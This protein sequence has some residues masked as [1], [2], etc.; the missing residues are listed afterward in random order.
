MARPTV[1]LPQPDSPTSASV[2]PGK[3]V[4]STPSTARTWPLT[5]FKHAGAD[6]EPGL[7]SRISSSA[8]ALSTVMAAP[9][10]PLSPPGGSAPTASPTRPCARAPRSGRARTP[11]EQRVWKRQPCGQWPGRGTAPLISSSRVPARLGLGDRAQ[12]ALRVGMARRAQQLDPRALLDDAARVH[13]GDPVG[14]LVD[15]AEV[16]G[17]EQHGRAGL[18]GE[19]AQQLQDLRADGGIE[20]RGRL[21]GD[22]QARAA[23]PWPWRSSRAA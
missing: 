7:R 18:G 12:Q 15:D 23:W 20:R 17:D 11:T 16:V 1:V 8:S 21:V 3:I 10:R 19:V 5:R 2:S 14:H 4:R 6:R 9:P 13:D 22:Q